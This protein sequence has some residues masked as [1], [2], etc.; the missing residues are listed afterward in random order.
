MW[1]LVGA[2]KLEN[3]NAKKQE[4]SPIHLTERA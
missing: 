2:G 1:W 3:Y 4:K